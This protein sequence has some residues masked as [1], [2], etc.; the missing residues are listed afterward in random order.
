MYAVFSNAKPC[1]HAA[2]RRSAGIETDD[3][4]LMMAYA[5]GDSSAFEQLYCR[6][7]SSLYQFMMNSCRND[8]LA[9][10]LYQDVW[11]R[12]VNA[13]AQ[14]DKSRPFKAW[15]FR[16]ARNRV[17]DHYRQL[18]RIAETGLE[19]DEHDSTHWTG[20]AESTA[21]EALASLSQRADLLRQALMRLPIN[22]RE[23]VLLRHIAGMSVKEV[24]TVVDEGVE[25]VKSRLRYAL[26]KLRSQL[27]ELS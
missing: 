20:N 26:V 22:Q 11:M 12:V 8:A 1:T 24:A 6:Y 18:S 10:E 15:L 13:R 3:A 9:G 5:Q 19:P 21:P 25:T 4:E 14:Y 16:I 17:T 27:Q 23:A 7:R 2:D